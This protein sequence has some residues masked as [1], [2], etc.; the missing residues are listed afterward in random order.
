MA[1]NDGIYVS[2]DVAIKNAMKEYDAAEIEATAA[3]QKDSMALSEFKKTLDELKKAENEL[4]GEMKAFKDSSQNT[5]IDKVSS[6]KLDASKKKY[7]EATQK[8]QQA[9]KKAEEAGD[10][11]TAARKKVKVAANI[12]SEI[13]VDSKENH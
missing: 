3:Q 1:Q 10:A 9:L 11:F 13:I 2:Y 7:D 8:A 4:D 12:V 5:S 6:Q